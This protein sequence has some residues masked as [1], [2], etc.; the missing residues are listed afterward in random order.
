M[1]LHQHD[2]E[3]EFKEGRFPQGWRGDAWCTTCDYVV[4]SR[5]A[6]RMEMFGLIR[7][8]N[9]PMKHE[10]PASTADSAMFKVTNLV[11]ER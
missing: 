5:E 3:Y 8:I 6:R 2:I 9:P 1:K 4:Y 10:K 11:V 7:S